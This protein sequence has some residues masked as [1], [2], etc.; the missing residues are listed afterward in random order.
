MKKTKEPIRKKQQTSI[1][2][3]SASRNKDSR[4]E[5]AAIKQGNLRRSAYERK[6]IPEDISLFTETEPD[7][8]TV[9]IKTFSSLISTLSGTEWR[10]AYSTEDT[11]IPFSERY[12]LDDQGIPR[13]PNHTYDLRR[14][15]LSNYFFITD[16][17]AKGNGNDA[18][19]PLQFPANHGLSF[20]Q[21]L[22]QKAYASNKS[23]IDKILQ[24]EV[25]F[26]TVNIWSK[27]LG[28]SNDTLVDVIGYIHAFL[29]A[30]NKSTQSVKYSTKKVLDAP[31]TN[32]NEG[33]QWSIE[34]ALQSSKGTL[35]H[36]FN[37]HHQLDSVPKNLSRSFKKHNLDELTAA[38]TPLFE[39]F[40]DIRLLQPENLILSSAVPTAFKYTLPGAEIFVF[41]TKQG[42]FSVVFSEAAE[43]AITVPGIHN[44][45]DKEKIINNL[46]TSGH[47]VFDNAMIEHDLQKIENKTILSEYAAYMRTQPPTSTS[48]APWELAILEKLQENQS[49][50]PMER[51]RIIKQ[52]AIDITLRTKNSWYHLNEIMSNKALNYL[53]LS[54]QLSYTTVPDGNPITQEL[55]SYLDETNL[56][57]AQKY[58]PQQF[59]RDFSSMIAQERNERVRHLKEYAFEGKEVHPRVKQYL[60]ERRWW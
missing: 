19:V 47:A 40:G 10:P 31:E 59:M 36:I 20:M 2:R 7:P 4:N 11:N 5:G 17:Q 50:S 29:R 54:Q 14:T 16:K 37:I 34:C 57:V 56:F 22:M 30:G 13:S 24:K 8:G 41:S 39:A 49:I 53:P 45:M 32:G 18:N 23:L 52:H 12:D 48:V 6:E 3:G 44:K 43:G 27:V 1:K 15:R 42:F 58:A 26:G 46:H 9:K 60:I 51:M 25:I 28:G 38:Y 35:A 21:S 33:A 55:L